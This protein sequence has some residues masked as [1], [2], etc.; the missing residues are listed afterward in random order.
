MMKTILMADDDI[1]DCEIAKIALE[2][3]GALVG[4][5][6][7]KDGMELI[8]YLVHSSVYGG[9][10]DLILLDLNMPKKD[11]RKA[12]VEIK[13]NPIFQQIPIVILTTSNQKEDIK[14]TMSAGAH[15]FITKPDGFE[16]W[17]EIM[18]SLV[19]KWLE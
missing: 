8:D 7:V 9:Q 17:C 2:E 10:P 11:G 15:D 3:S 18:K 16:D 19:K 13:S 12:L 1:E 5:N 14:L 4:F 6:T